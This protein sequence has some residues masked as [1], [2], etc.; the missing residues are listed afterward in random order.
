MSA[1]CLV[2]SSSLVLVL[3][4]VLLLVL[5]CVM[6]PSCHECADRLDRGGS[7]APSLLGAAGAPPCG[8]VLLSRTLRGRYITYI[9]ISQGRGEGLLLRTVRKKLHRHIAFVR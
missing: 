6:R 3:V 5:A 4:L 9:T 1:S 2:V 8:Q 7:L